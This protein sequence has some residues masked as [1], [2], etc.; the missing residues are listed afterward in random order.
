MDVLDR[1]KYL[2]SNG[3]VGNTEFRE[4][5]SSLL[6]ARVEG[7]RVSQSWKNVELFET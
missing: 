3:P 2:A 1:T 4:E 6:Q 7:K 5:A